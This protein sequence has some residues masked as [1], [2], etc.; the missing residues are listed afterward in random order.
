MVFLLYTDDRNQY[1]QFLDQLISIDK[2]K[3]TDLLR[4]WAKNKAEWKH[5]ILE[6]LCLIQAKLAIHKLGLDYSE[7]SE[8]FLP[9]NYYTTTHVHPIIKLLYYVCEQLTIRESK[10]LI[11]Y[12]QQ[13]YPSVRNFNYSDNGDYLE[14]YFMNWILEK[15]VIDVG[16]HRDK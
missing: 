5:F 10:K 16:H 4:A 3:D 15:N 12:M 14:I 11:D 6:A 13:K 9:L 8:R 2:E 7:L 1:K